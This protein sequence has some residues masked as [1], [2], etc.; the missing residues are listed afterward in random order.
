[1]PND[2]LQ[3]S[4]AADPPS[5]DCISDVLLFKYIEGEATAQE[6]AAI[7][8]HLNECALCFHVVAAMRRNEGVPFT[9][10]EELEV[11][12]LLKLSPQAQVAKILDYE[13]ELNPHAAPEEDAE[14]ET[15]ESRSFAVE[16]AYRKKRSAILGWLQTPLV[17]RPAFAALFVLLALGGRWGWRYAQTDYKIHQAAALLQKEHTVFIKDARL[18]GGY[19][20]SGMSVLMGTEKEEKYSARAEKL[21]AQAIKNGATSIPAK[22]QLAKIFLIE[23]KYERADSLLQELAPFANNSASL[24]NDLGVYHFQKQNWDSAAKYFTAAIA[25]DPKFLE[26]RYNLALANAEAGAIEEAIRIMNEYLEL[27]TDEEWQAAG[28]SLIKNDWRMK[29]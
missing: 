21:T 2:M 12:K 3:N 25:A 19:G 26:A 16:A 27:E 20:S 7:Q 5:A 15:T 18:S 6:A 4:L 24:L 17:W 23:G 13:K 28:E 1:M 29:K 11:A 10:M 22:Q 8:E 9:A 14:D